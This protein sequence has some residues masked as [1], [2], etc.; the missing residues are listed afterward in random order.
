MSVDHEPLKKVSFWIR[1]IKKEKV[2]VSLSIENN[3]VGS[4]LHG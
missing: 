1:I 4:Y 2:K 3:L